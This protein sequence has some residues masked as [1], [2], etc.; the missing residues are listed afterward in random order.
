ML[1]IW[2]IIALVASFVAVWCSLNTRR[3]LG[4]VKYSEMVL[5]EQKVMLNNVLKLNEELRISVDNAVELVEKADEQHSELRGNY[6]MVC[7][8]LVVEDDRRKRH[9]IFDDIKLAF[10][11]EALLQ[12]VASKETNNEGDG[13]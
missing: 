4:L 7:K 5:G 11:R 9:K 3:S 12:M 2:M 6:E 13:E 10:D 8:A 1:N